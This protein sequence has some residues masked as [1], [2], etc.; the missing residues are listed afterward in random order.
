MSLNPYLLLKYKH[1]FSIYFG[2][3]WFYVT[4]FLQ[5]DSKY[6]WD[7]YVLDILLKTNQRGIRKD[8]YESF[9]ISNSWRSHDNKR[10]IRLM[11]TS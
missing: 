11:V 4:S 3:K 2:L 7:G 10:R 1:Q 5:L 6:E 9:Q 8:S